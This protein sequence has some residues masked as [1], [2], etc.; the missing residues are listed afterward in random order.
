MI[1]LA[2]ISGLG[3]Y[4]KKSE[5]IKDAK[6]SAK[7]SRTIFYPKDS[8]KAFLVEN[9]QTIELRCDQKL[10]KLLL[11]KYESVMASRYFGKNGIEIVLSGQLT[12]NE[13]Q[14]LIRLSYNLTTSIK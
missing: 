5:S 14:D 6:S 12:E 9:A 10:A 2:E 1:N 7:K 4:T 11:E 8:E 3:A 13:I